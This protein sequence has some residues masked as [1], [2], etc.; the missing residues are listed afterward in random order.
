MRHSL[1]SDA[2]PAGCSHQERSGGNL[3]SDDASP[4]FCDGLEIDSFRNHFQRLPNHDARAAES[5]FAMTDGRVHDNVKPEV[6]DLARALLRSI[7]SI[8]RRAIR[9]LPR[10]CDASRRAIPPL[11][12][13]D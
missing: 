5:W 3:G 10:W 13:V 11:G 12:P 9:E 7:N 2:D 4:R 6:P 1:K 8:L